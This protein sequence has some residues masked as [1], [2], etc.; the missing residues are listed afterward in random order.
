M[1]IL[2]HRVILLSALSYLIYAAILGGKYIVYFEMDENRVV[3]AQLPRQF[4][5][6]KRLA[7][8]AIIA[9]F[10]TQN[11]TL[12]GNSFLASTHSSTI[13]NWKAVKSVKSVRG[14]HVIYVNE[15]LF[16]NQVYAEDEDFNF[17][18]NYIRQHCQNAKIS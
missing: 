15:T 9:G 2:W 8:V 10:L 6:M 14:R 5:K 18:E 16:K 3:H 17:V 11:L 1:T 7:G 12:M 13:S 4:N